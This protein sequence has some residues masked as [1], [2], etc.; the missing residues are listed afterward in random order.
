MFLAN[1]IQF[2]KSYADYAAMAVDGYIVARLTFLEPVDAVENAVEGD[3]GAS[4]ED[5]WMYF[6]FINKKPWLVAI[7]ECDKVEPQF[8][9][10]E[11]RVSI[12][13]FRLI[14]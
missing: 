13:D 4:G 3:A 5:W 1:F 2:L 8:Y 10:A 11:V 9:D 7:M 14:R 12:S 6:G